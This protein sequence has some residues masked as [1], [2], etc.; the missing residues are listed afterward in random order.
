MARKVE[1]EEEEYETTTFHN[2]TALLQIASWA[3]VTGWVIAAIY[4]FSWISDLSQMFTGGGLQLPA[5]LM[6]KLVFFANLVYPV[7]MGAFYFL[8]MQGLAQGLYLG[9][10]LYMTTEEDEYED[11]DQEG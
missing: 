2:E 10:D 3:K 8:I 4:L 11:D 9:L 5:D 7:G 6:G 1:R